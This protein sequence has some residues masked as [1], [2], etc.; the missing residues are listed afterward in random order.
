MKDKTDIE[1]KSIIEQAVAELHNRGYNVETR[2]ALGSNRRM[3][4][5]ECTKIIKL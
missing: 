2:G 4:I 1:L 3:P 5:I